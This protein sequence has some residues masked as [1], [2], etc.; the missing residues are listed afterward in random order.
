MF[1]MPH[2]IRHLFQKQAQCDHTIPTIQLAQ[3]KN[4]FK[5]PLHAFSSMHRLPSAA[6]LLVLYTPGIKEK[7]DK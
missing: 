1:L 2:I 4:H 6:F 7:E 3:S 5:S